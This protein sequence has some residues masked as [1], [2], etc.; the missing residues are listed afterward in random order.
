[1]FVSVKFHPNSTSTYRA[2]IRRLAPSRTELLDDANDEGGISGQANKHSLRAHGHTFV[3]QNDTLE[4]CFL[5]FPITVDNR[6]QNPMVEGSI[7]QQAMASPHRPQPKPN[8]R[9]S[10][11]SE[12]KAVALQSAARRDTI[13]RS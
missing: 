3:G 5:S 10:A 12:R 9:I 6:L 2:T 13:V 4:K 11:R 8:N 7:L 1:M